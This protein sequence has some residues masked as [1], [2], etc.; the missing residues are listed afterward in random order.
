M[1]VC[2]C[3]HVVRRRGTLSACACGE[4]WGLVMVRIT[5]LV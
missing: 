4:V 1:H 5:H 2:V 3:M